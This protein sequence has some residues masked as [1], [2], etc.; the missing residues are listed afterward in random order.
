MTDY[1]FAIFGIPGTKPREYEVKKCKV[2]SKRYGIS[3]I[4]VGNS[5]VQIEKADETLFKTR[6]E[7][8][9]YIKNVLTKI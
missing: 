1:V 8:N 2:I 9:Q 6:K 4:E 3:L 7:A 5:A